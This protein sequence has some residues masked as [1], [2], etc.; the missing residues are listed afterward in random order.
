[1][2]IAVIHVPWS[3]SRAGEAR[4]SRHHFLPE[5][6]LLTPEDAALR[7]RAHPRGIT[8]RAPAGARALAHAAE[9]PGCVIAG[10]G[11]LALHGLPFLA[12]GHDTVLIAPR[13]GNSLGDALSPTIVRRGVNPGEVA[14]F[15]INSFTFRLSTP[16]AATIQA[17]KHHRLG[18][19][20]A[21]QLVD[22]VRR[23]LGVDPASL[24]DAGHY[25]L[26][27][28]W[29]TQ[30]VGLSSE[31]A[32]SPKETEMR[33]LTHEVARDFGLTLREQHPVF[34][35]GRIV[36]VFD[37][38]LLEARIGLMYDGK[39]HW[40]YHQ[41]QKDS[42]INLEV[43]ELGWTPVR[44]SSGTLP[45]LPERLTGLLSDKSA[46]RRNPTWG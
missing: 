6:Q 15:T 11:A 34:R 45:Q 10:Y 4:I 2:S 25:R 9:H 27:K 46:G 23:Y 37:L 17:L 13:A 5:S 36:T 7:A 18:L 30:V 8:Y 43:T 40:D 24:L 28:K 22:C 39:H 35:G 21:V 32:D 44:F 19:L 16:P 1:M 33:L 42:L 29:L 38:A 31:F 14:A 3:L 26:R 12:E 41:R 20:P